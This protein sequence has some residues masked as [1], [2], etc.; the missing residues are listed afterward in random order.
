MLQPIVCSGFTT[1]K[2]VFGIISNEPTSNLY[3]TRLKSNW[4]SV[5]VSSIRSTLTISDIEE[6]PEKN[7]GRLLVSEFQVFKC[8]KEKTNNNALPQSEDQSKGLIEDKLKTTNTPAV[9][10][11]PYTQ[12]PI[13]SMSKQN[14]TGYIGNTTISSPSWNDNNYGT[15]RPLELPNS[16]YFFVLT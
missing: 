4:L 16:M 3:N 14:S 10:S 2:T 12:S 6:L 9:A 13:T 15:T 1:P 11:A 5:P 8:A 7:N